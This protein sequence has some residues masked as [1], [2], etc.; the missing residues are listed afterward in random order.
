M[1]DPEPLASVT[2]TDILKYISD[3]RGHYMTY[4]NHKEVSA[5]AGVVLYVLATAQIALVKKEALATPRAAV[6]LTTFVAILFG[7]VLVYLKTQFDLRR[8]AA[9]YVGALHYLNVEY[10]T[11][12][13]NADHWQLIPLAQWHCVK[14]KSQSRLVLPARVKELALAINQHGQKSRIRLQY[15]AYSIVILATFAVLIRLWYFR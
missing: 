2:R 6:A 5:W 11:T 1:A 8:E 3:T 12:E 4:H 10:L 14:T 7:L 9:N 15:A 13:F